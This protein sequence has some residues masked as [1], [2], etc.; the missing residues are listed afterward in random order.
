MVGGFNNYSLRVQRRMV[1]E[2]VEM[3]DS[4]WEHVFEYR[5]DFQREC[6]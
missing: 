5:V 3:Q 4:R 1:S 2:P 6:L